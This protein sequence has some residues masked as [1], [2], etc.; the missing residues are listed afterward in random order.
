VALEA[1]GS[2]P[3]TRPRFFIVVNLLAMSFFDF[4]ETAY[5][6]LKDG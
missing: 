1:A 5:M 6:Y 3:V 2:N 4:N